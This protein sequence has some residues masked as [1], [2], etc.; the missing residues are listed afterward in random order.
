MGPHGVGK[1]DPVSASQLAWCGAVTASP[2]S[3][4][5]LSVS[6]SLLV[7]GSSGQAEVHSF[8]VSL[9]ECFSHC[10]TLFST[11][12]PQSVPLSLFPIQGCDSV[13]NR[14]HHPVQLLFLP[15]GKACKPGDSSACTKGTKHTRTY[16]HSRLGACT[17]TRQSVKPLDS[18]VTAP[19]TAKFPL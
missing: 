10:Q 12:K 17:Y 5:C 8:L 3:A 9:S 14:S 1:T 6:H 19:T 11:L 18:R 7:C 13:L 2:S 16:T 4:Q 15:L